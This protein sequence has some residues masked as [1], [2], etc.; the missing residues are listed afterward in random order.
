MY[1]N[2][3]IIEKGQILAFGSQEYGQVMN[4]L[5]SAVPLIRLLTH[6]Y[7]SLEMAVMVNTSKLP[8]KCPLPHNLIHVRLSFSIRVVVGPF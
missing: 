4:A 6:S 8:A 5:A 2:Y 7:K 3:L 1:F